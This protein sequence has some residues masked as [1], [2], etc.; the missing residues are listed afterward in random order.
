[1]NAEVRTH[2]E[3]RYTTW[4]CAQTAENRLDSSETWLCPAHLLNASVLAPTDSDRFSELMRTYLIARLNQLIE[5]LDNT[6]SRHLTIRLR[7]AVHHI[8]R[9]QWTSATTAW[10]RRTP[11]L[12]R[13]CTPDRCRRSAAGSRVP[14]FW[15]P[16]GGFGNGVPATSWAEIA[17]MGEDQLAE[18]LFALARRLRR[19]PNRSARRRD[20]PA[21]G[22]HPCS[23]ATPRTC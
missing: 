18:V 22:R 6:P 16:P 17:D 9:R 11:S 21:A 5:R 10:H 3:L 8:I 14:M 23:T 2:A 4:L 7:R 1:M 15:L 20:V 19:H 13:R 12:P